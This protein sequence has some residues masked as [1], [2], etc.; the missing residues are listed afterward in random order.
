MHVDQV[1][2]SQ[3][4]LLDAGYL[5]P[6]LGRMLCLGAVWLRYDSICKTVGRAYDVTQD[7]TV[8][9]QYL[10]DTCLMVSL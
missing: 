4:G 8:K 2:G 3:V 7:G 5:Q 9:V 10:A 1:P 6:Q